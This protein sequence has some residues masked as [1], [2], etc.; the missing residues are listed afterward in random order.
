MEETT[1][2]LY[3]QNEEIIEK[4]ETKAFFVLISQDK[5]PCCLSSDPKRRE[6]HMRKIRKKAEQLWNDSDELDKSK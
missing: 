3:S 1:G 4:Y 2:S 5:I 6:K